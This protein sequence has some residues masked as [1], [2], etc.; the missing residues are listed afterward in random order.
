MGPLLGNA[1]SRY[2]DIKSVF[3]DIQE[4]NN[5]LRSKIPELKER[6]EQIKA[7]FDQID[8]IASVVSK[9]DAAVSATERR[10][11]EVMD[12]YDKSTLKQLSKLF[13]RGKRTKVRQERMVWTPLPIPELDDIFGRR[14]SANSDQDSNN[15]VSGQEEEDLD[16]ISI[17]PQMQSP[18]SLPSETKE[19][20]PSEVTE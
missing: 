1:T 8:A 14:K 19:A 13:G 17:E 20:P 2:E 16:Y 3:Q 12:V 18:D 7:T 4:E 9:I 15:Q 10:F 6:G 5:I 11:D